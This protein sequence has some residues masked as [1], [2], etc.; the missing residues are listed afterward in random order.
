MNDDRH[1][2]TARAIAPEDITVGDYVAVLNWIDEVFPIGALFDCSAINTPHTLEMIRVQ[3]IPAA[4]CVPLKVEAICLPWVLVK[5]PMPSARAMN[6]WNSSQRPLLLRTLDVRRVR[7]A[8]LSDAF[9]EQLYRAL[10]GRFQKKGEPA[11]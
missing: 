5:S 7:L 3:R 8:R 6:N 9:G 10:K 1:N 2:L 4:A 11:S